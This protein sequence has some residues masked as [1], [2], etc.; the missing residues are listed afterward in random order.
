MTEAPWFNK[1]KSG[2]FRGNKEENVKVLEFF[3][4]TTILAGTL[5]LAFA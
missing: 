4:V 3:I 5:M 2:A 1:Q